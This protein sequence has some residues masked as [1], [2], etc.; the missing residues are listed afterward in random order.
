MHDYCVS[1][2]I[3]T[4]ISLRKFLITTLSLRLLFSGTYSL[5]NSA[6]NKAGR[7]YF[8]CLLLSEIH[9]PSECILPL[10]TWTITM[11]F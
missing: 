10:S 8:V 4:P 11:L 2:C 6:R 9:D 1:P 7:V 5:L 3:P